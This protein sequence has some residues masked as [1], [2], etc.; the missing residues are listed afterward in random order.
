M[1]RFVVC[2]VRRAD[3]RPEEFR[4]EFDA[5]GMMALYERVRILSGASR[6]V[7][8]FRMDTAFGENLMLA[9]Q[10]EVHCD[11]MVELLWPEGSPPK[12]SI[13]DPQLKDLIGEIAALSAVVYDLSRSFAVFLGD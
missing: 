10:A 5:S 2:I 3:Q 6:V 4:R 13:D 9:R 8:S 1:M 7:R 12:L 11:A